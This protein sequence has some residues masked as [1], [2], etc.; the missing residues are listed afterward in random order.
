MHNILINNGDK[1]LKGKI[2]IKGDRAIHWQDR[3]T[4]SFKID[5]RKET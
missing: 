1:K 2:R 3:N 5:M 4:T